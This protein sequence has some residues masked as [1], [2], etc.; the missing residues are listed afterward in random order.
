MGNNN[1]D[2]RKR[3]RESDKTPESDREESAEVTEEEGSGS[4]TDKEEKLK[5]GPRKIGEGPG[6]LR[7]RSDWFQKRHR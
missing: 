7:R 6:N 3:N 2:D 5:P 4:D 1:A